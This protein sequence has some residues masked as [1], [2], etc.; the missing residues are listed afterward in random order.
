MSSPVSHLFISLNV[1]LMAGI[2][3]AQETS[4]PLVD[5]GLTPPKISIIALGSK[6]TRRYSTPS[7][8][9]GN[10]AAENLTAH[11][12]KQAILLEAPKY[13]TP[14]SQLFYKKDGNAKWDRFDIGFNNQGVL[15]KVSQLKTLKFFSKLPIDKSAKPLFKLPPLEQNSNTLFFLTPT[16]NQRSL[17]KKIPKFTTVPLT[18]PSKGD[19]RI[20]LINTSQ[21]TVNIRVGDSKKLSLKPGLQTRIDLTFTANENRVTLIVKGVNDSKIALR[22]SIK[23]LPKTTKVYAFYNAAPKSNGGRTLGTFRAVYD[24]PN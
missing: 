11:P 1:C 12:N 9:L 3:S 7:R 14:P 18:W 13:S 4:V 8:H 20:L 24:A 19:T 17:W 22:E 2:L 6:P 10:Q 5:Q 21:Q 15:R 23:H 16:G